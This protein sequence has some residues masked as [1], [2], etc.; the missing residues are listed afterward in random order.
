MIQFDPII[1]G[2]QHVTYHREPTRAEI[3][4]GEG[5]THYRDFPLEEVTKPD[6]KIKRWLFSKDDRLRYYR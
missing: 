1:G 3:R 4:F 6:G 5:A 2:V